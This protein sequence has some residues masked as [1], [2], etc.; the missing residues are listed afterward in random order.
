MDY[1]NKLLLAKEALDSGSYDKE[2]IEYI[3]PEL[4]K[5]VETNLAT[6]E[7]Y[8]LQSKLLPILAE[9]A[10]RHLPDGKELTLNY[11]FCQIIIK[12]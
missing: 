12:M 2:T 4:K 10:S 7:I 5:Y 8:D 3:F 11:P 9:F 1:E 6:K